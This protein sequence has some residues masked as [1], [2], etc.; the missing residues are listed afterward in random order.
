MPKLLEVKNLKTCFFTEDGVKY[1][2][3]GVDFS[4]DRGKTLC[5]VG[6]SGCGKS[7]TSLSILR[8]VPSPSGK[9]VDGSIKFNGEELLDKT[10]AQMCA[11]R[12]NKISMIFQ[13]PM[14]SLNPVYTIG[15]QMTEVYRQHRQLSKQDA[16]DK[17][18]EML[19]MVGISAPKQR[20]KQHP[21]QLSGGMRQR[22]MIA[23]ALACNPSLLIADEP[24]TAL[25]VTIQAQ[26]LEL[27]KEIKDRL[28]TSIM[29]ITHDL[30]VVAD[31][32]ED[33]LVMYAGKVMEYSD[34]FSIFHNP[35]HPYTIGLMNSIPR[36]DKPGDR[37]H[38]IKGM[39]PNLL[40]M[41]S[42]CR[43]SPRCDNA[44][45][46]CHEKEPP[47]VDIRGHKVRCW[48]YTNQAKED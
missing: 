23:M 1:A 4:L 38:V 25:D 46:I 28:N 9:I 33:V 16:Y 31:M 42:G 40:K 29:L 39:V 22:V 17:S 24:T 11:I 41:P 6:E 20:M 43:F 34:V 15:F 44:I 14:T 3:D 8:L 36:L 7:M 5:I 47:L 37:L 12:G 45:P 32:A 10:E 19:H 48:L 35:L 13:E 2:V 18:I 26:I 21:H 27:M 30:G